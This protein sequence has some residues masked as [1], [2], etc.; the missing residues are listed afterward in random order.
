MFRASI[1][2]KQPSDGR[3]SEDSYFQVKIIDVKW[4]FNKFELTWLDF[5]KYVN[6]VDDKYDELEA[7]KSR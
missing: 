6:R 3:A 2:A 4:W 7:Q 5:L 1:S